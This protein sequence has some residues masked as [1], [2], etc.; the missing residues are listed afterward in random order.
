MR[1]ELNT[2]LRLN[3]AADQKLK[4][5]GRHVIDRACTLQL[6]ILFYHVLFCAPLQDQ[7]MAA[8]PY[9]DRPA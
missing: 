3:F 2:R 8:E 5:S 6:V 4:F 7:S 9:E 1:T